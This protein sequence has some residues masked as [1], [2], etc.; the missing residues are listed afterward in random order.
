MSSPLSIPKLDNTMGAILIGSFVASALYG[1]T[2]HQ[3][4]RYFRMYPDDPSGLKSLAIVLW[5]LDTLH[6][7][8]CTHSS[9][10]Y[11]VSHFLQPLTL[12]EG[13]WV[14]SLCFLT[15]S[16]LKGYTFWVLASALG[17][18]ALS[19][20]LLTTTLFYY[21]VRNGRGFSSSDTTLD[22]FLVYIINTGL[23]TSMLTVADLIC[24]L[25]MRNNLVFLGIYFVTSKMYVNSLMAVLNARRSSYTPSQ[26]GS[27][28]LGRIP[29][30][31]IDN[32]W[33][34]RSASLV[35]RPVFDVR[36]MRDSYKF[37][38]HMSP[39]EEPVSLLSSS[40]GRNR[41]N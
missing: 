1:L 12:L 28:D 26:I 39:F 4:F 38:G 25:T 29:R 5:V 33:D 10:Y 18:A 31:L 35:G 13:V 20:I 2:T 15:H 41:Y 7:I 16:L 23:L 9:Y 37:G 22:K 40:P 8:L 6:L 3:F 27:F 32:S 21:L 17:V 19:D 11:L 24:G 34:K 14:S 30:R 36:S